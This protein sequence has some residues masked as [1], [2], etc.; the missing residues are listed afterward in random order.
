MKHG[1]Q[2][3]DHMV[4]QLVPVSLVL[5]LVLLQAIP[6]HLPALS[7]VVPALP[8]IAIYYWSVYRPDLLVPSVAFATGLVNDVVLGA[9]IGI[10]SLAF[11]VIQGMTASQTRFFNGKSFLV[12]WSGFALLAA[13]AM[14]VELA[15]AG[16]VYGRTPVAS[17]LAIQYALTVCLYPLVSW[18]FSRLQLFWLRNE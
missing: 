3:V 9:P 11:L 6:W 5:V 1:S 15:M 8:M 17:A 10:S 16:L 18:I 13:A 7:G 2:R 4:R 14:L 12:I